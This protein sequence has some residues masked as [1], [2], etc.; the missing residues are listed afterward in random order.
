MLDKTCLSCKEQITKRHQLKY[1]SN[2]CQHEWQ[3]KTYINNW[4]T[5][6]T[7]ESIQTVNISRYL[8][9]YFFEKFKEKCSAC[10]WDKKHPTTGH[11]PLE[12][13]HIDGNSN[14]NEESNLRILCPNCHALTINYKSLNK[15]K[16]RAWRKKTI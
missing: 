16:G 12:I 13:D 2:K 4:R 14:N 10:G 5:N 1:C 3:Y 6:K 9:R 7:S 11:P 8:K 15:G